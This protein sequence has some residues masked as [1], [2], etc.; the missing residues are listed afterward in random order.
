MRA[1]SDLYV[2]TAQRT[3]GSMLDFAVN[4]CGYRIGH[5]FDLFIQSGLAH[6]FGRGEPNIVAGC[7]GIELVFQVLAETKDPGTFMDEATWQKVKDFTPIGGSTPEYW[8]GWA[9]A[10]YQWE[11]GRSFEGIQQLV[12]I[13]RVRELYHPYHEMDITQFCDCMDDLCSDVQVESALKGLRILAGLSQSQLAQAA[14]I[15]VRTLQQYEQRRKD[16]NKAHAETVVKLSHVLHC[17]VEDLLE[18]SSQPH[19][20]FDYAYVE[21]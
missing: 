19:H 5:F 8:A 4:G 21:I 10:Y 3:L 14:G 11:C 6:R 7:S 12:P 15:P 9:L 20:C 13:E 16:I 17:N 2:L 1:Y 18:Y